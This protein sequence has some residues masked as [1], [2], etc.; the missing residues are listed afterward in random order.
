M[1]EDLAGIGKA[2]HG[3]FILRLIGLSLILRLKLVSLMIFAAVWA[4]S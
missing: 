1:D 3:F 2:S 4:E